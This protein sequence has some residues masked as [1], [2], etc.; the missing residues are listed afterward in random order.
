MNAGTFVL[1]ALVAA[2]AVYWAL[3][4]SQRGISAQAT[5]P[6]VSAPAPTDAAALARL[7]GASS[8]AP[9]AAAAPAAASRFSLV[10]V[11]AGPKR[12]AALIAVDGKAAKPFRVGS[13]VTDGFLLQ[14]VEA[15]RAMLAAEPDGPVLVTLELPALKN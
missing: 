11:A 4:I 7:L 8:N 1:W 13:V 15:R 12:G 14:S 3:K 5:P 9:E 6:P 10:G 2:S